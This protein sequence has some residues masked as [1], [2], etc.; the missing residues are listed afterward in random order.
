MTA[1]KPY[2]MTFVEFAE[3]ILPS[4]GTSLG[5]S[6]LSSDNPE[7]LTS[8]WNSADKRG[9]YHVFWHNDPLKNEL[10]QEAQKYQLDDLSLYPITTRLGLN[11]EV[12]KDNIKASILLAVRNAWITA[13]QHHYGQSTTTIPSCTLTNAAAAEYVL[14]TSGLVHPWIK[15]QI[16]QHIA[17]QNLKKLEQADKAELPVEMSSDPNWPNTRVIHVRATETCPHEQV[18]R[19]DQRTML[20]EEMKD[21]RYWVNLFRHTDVGWNSEFEMDAWNAQR[22]IDIANQKITALQKVIEKQRTFI[23]SADR[24][25]SKNKRHEAAIRKSKKIGRPEKSPERQAVAIKFTSQWVQSLMEALKVNNS[26]QLECAVDGS[27][28]RNWR[29]WLS[30]QAVPTHNNLSE[31]LNAEITQGIY[32]GKPLYDVTIT[33]K[34]ND[35]LSLISLT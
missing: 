12:E 15:E 2:E 18:W 11:P 26:A 10:P 27:N 35:L 17:E 8:V 14:L 7:W 4:W 16:R 29:R 33:P 1:K 13:I 9:I 22:D 30:G 5:S 20:E 21:I 24:I 34:H 25:I 19:E 32:K 23:Q 28:Q 31:L 6:T 3:A